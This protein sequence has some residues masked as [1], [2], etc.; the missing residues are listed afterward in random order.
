MRCGAVQCNSSLCVQYDYE[1]NARD[2]ASAHAAVAAPPPFLP[3]LDDTARVSTTTRQASRQRHE[4]E[5]G[6][7]LQLQQQVTSES[8][9][10]D[11][12]SSPVVWGE[13]VHVRCMY[14][15]LSIPHVLRNS[16]WVHPRGCLP[17]SMR[18][19]DN[20]S[21]R[22]RSA[23]DRKDGTRDSSGGAQGSVA[24]SHAAPTPSMATATPCTTSANRGSQEQWVTLSARDAMQ[25]GASSPREFSGQ[26][27]TCQS[28]SV[29]QMKLHIG[30]YSGPPTFVCQ[31]SLQCCAQ[32]N[33]NAVV[34]APPVVIRGRS[35]WFRPSW[36]MSSMSLVG[37]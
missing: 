1:Y 24:C 23:A 10:F 34:N 36:P 25:P 14:L 20:P 17:T 32:W 9:A 4:R 33:T 8:M 21:T 16:S 27:P 31:P 28:W 15:Y 29:A 30:S 6:T 12:H 13:A 35:L 2:A 18:L 22:R 5:R 11:F 3:R 37:P 7:S 19:K 26:S